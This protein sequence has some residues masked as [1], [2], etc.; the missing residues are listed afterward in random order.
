M[1]GDTVNC[2][3]GTFT[4]TAAHADAVSKITEGP[5]SPD[6]QI[7]WFGIAIG[8]SFSG[9]TVTNATNNKT[10][11]IPAPLGVL[12]MKCFI[13][14][15]PTYTL[16]NLTIA[17]FKRMYL[18]SVAEF[19]T[20]L[21]SENPNL[22][23]FRRSDHKRL[24]WH[25]LADRLIKNYHGTTWYRDTVQRNMGL[26][27]EQVDEFYRLFLA[28]GGDHCEGGYGPVPV[29]PS[30]AL[31]DWVENNNA[32]DTLFARMVDDTNT[33]VTRNLCRYPWQLVYLGGDARDA[34]SFACD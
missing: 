16:E 5:R 2:P 27:T 13:S 1:V 29:E 32:L 28:S 14:K 33:T 8:A 34:H 6:G 11:V 12:W 7:S 24:P 23:E 31:V 20:I 22:T 26:D 15:D 4:I 9:V 21:G 3:N 25:G 10:S 18:Q 19:T 30:K 17:N